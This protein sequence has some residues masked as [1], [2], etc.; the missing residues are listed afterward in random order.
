MIQVCAVCIYIYS[1]FTHTCMYSYVVITRGSILRGKLPLNFATIL[2]IC[3]T[4]SRKFV[5]SSSVLPIKF[6]HKNTE[7]YC[8]VDSTRMVH[9][10]PSLHYL[11]PY[12]PLANE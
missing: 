5:V 3:L 4:K 8:R 10:F 2:K 9:C 7:E 12:Y 1:I 6:V 11:S